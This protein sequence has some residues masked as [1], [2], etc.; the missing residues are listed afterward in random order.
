MT[1][2]SETK[3]LRL[4]RRWPP[5]GTK[6]GDGGPIA[7]AAPTSLSHSQMGSPGQLAAAGQEKPVSCAC[8][9]E[10]SYVASIFASCSGEGQGS[11]A[12]Y[13]GSQRK[14]IPVQIVK[15]VN[16]LGSL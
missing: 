10:R 9:Q 15:R 7:P 11:G 8:S 1:F 3:G 14:L 16:R 13:R 6:Q 2:A 5:Q 4:E 12:M